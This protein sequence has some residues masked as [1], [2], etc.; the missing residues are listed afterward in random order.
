MAVIAFSFTAVFN[1]RY[2]STD[3]TT[4]E[5]LGIGRISWWASVILV[6]LWSIIVQKIY[7]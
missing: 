3:E 2:E 5:F 1:Y 4:R 7:P 6:Y